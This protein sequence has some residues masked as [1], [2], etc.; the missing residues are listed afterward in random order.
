MER[1]TVLYVDRLEIG[2]TSTSNVVVSLIAVVRL[3]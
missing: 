2:E 1:G 3:S